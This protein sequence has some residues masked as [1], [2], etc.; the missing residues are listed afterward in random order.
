VR[1]FNGVALDLTPIEFR[2]LKTLASAA[3]PCFHRLIGPFAS[4]T[5]AP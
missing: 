4:R 1:R 3:W 2:L 5:S